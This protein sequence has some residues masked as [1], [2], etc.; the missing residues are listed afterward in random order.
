MFAEPEE[1]S[2]EAPDAGASDEAP[3]P[4]GEPQRE[5]EP[6]ALV[7]PAVITAVATLAVGLGAALSF[8]PLQ[9]A[10]S[11]AEAVFR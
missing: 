1:E 8:A 9:V 3:Q 4:E 10:E 11:I 6:G 2:G 7:V 5:K